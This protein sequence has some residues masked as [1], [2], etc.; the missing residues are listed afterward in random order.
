M[1]EV[2][3]YALG[4]ISQMFSQFGYW[5][6]LLI[7]FVTLVMIPTN[8]LVKKIF[9]K[10]TSTSANRIRKTVSQ[11]LVFVFSAIALVIYELIATK[12]VSLQFVLYNLIPCGGASMI[13]WAIIKIARD[14]GIKPLIKLLTQTNAVKK[15]LKEIPLDK[16]IKNTIFD[17]LVKLV[18]NS[19]GENAEIVLNKTVEITQRA[20]QMLNGFVEN[21]KEIAKNFVDALIQKF[22]KKED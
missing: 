14:C 18:E 2:L 1:E 6:F 11:S 12:N 13:L 16:E 17:A 9:E 5:C 20:E 19:D 15:L 4:Y 8:I 22:T 7:A 3:E 10:Y 21:P